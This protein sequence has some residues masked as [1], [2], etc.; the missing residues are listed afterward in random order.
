[1]SVTVDISDAMKAFSRLS[2]GGADRVSKIVL[3]SGGSRLLKETRLA[4]SQRDHTLQRL[5]EMGHPYARAGGGKPRIHGGQPLIHTQSG[6]M[7]AALQGK[8]TSKRSY[9]WGFDESKAPHAK[10]VL[11]GT[12]VMLP[13]DVFR[14]VYADKKKAK[15]IIGVMEKAMIRV[16]KTFNK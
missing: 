10:M 3:T 11:F 4:I 6:R 9:S 16:I 8:L 7:L 15:S 14:M 2:K 1:M 12:R 13:R 5:H